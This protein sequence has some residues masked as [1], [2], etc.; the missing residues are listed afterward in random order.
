MEAGACLGLK[1][2]FFLILKWWQK[3]AGSP[4]F[5]NQKNNG[6]G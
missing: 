4:N 1:S 3:G 6:Y 2:C 5:E